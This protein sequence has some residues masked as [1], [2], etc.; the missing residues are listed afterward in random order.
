MKFSHVLVVVCTL[1]AACGYTA[2]AQSPV[3]VDAEMLQM[4]FPSQHDKVVSLSGPWS[5]V[6]DGEESTVSL[7]AIEFAPEATFTKKIQLD[8]SSVDNYAWSIDF[9]GAGH[10]VDVFVNDQFVGTHIGGDVRF[11]QAI[12]QSFLVAGENIVTVA[13]NGE[14]SPSGTVPV[15]GGSLTPSILA[16]VHRDVFLVGRPIVRVGDANLKTTNISSDQATLSVNT[17]IVTDNLARFVL[18]TDSVEIVRSEVNVDVAVVL[19]SPSG[20]IVDSVYRTVVMSSNRSEVV[21]EE[22]SVVGPSLWALGAPS[23]YSLE[24]VASVSGET[25]DAWK[26]DVSLFTVGVD[27]RANAMLVNGTPQRLQAIDYFESGSQDANH[28]VTMQRMRQDIEKILTLGANCVRFPYGMPH[29]VLL[30][31]C[32]KNGLAVMIDMPVVNVPSEL[33]GTDNF[34]STA[35]N[36]AGEYTNTAG[37]VGCILGFGLSTGLHEGKA[38]TYRYLDALSSRFAQ[39]GY[40]T[41]KTWSGDQLMFEKRGID[42]VLLDEHSETY[43]EQYARARELLSGT[44]WLAHFG[45]IVEPN[46]HQGYSNP[47]S[48]EAQAKHIR[49]RVRFLQEQNLSAGVVLWSYN[50]YTTARPL[51]LVRAD[52]PNL[53]SSGLVAQNREERFSYALTKALFNDEKEPVIAAGTWE[54][55]KP[56]MYTFLSIALLVLTLILIN[57]SRRFRENVARALVRPYNFYADIRDQ[58]IL[59]SVRTIILALVVALASG[60]YFSAITYTL[61]DTLL[62]DKWM[63]LLLPWNSL[64]EVADTLVWM[65]LGSTLALAGL[66]MLLLLC[67]AATIRIGSMFVRSRIFFSD[68]MI[69]ATWGALPAVFLLFGT[70]ALYKLLEIPEALGPILI[71]LVV[72][73]LW[74]LYRVLRGTAVIF[75]IRSLYAYTGGIALL[76]FVASLFTWYYNANWSTLA[77]VEYLLQ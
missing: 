34:I 58:R 10:R 77:Y 41:Y 5:R 47:Y 62:L 18:A 48:I 45:R 14:L 67:V 42:F 61:R 70:A 72:F 75:D 1:L 68:A 55:D 31:L 56:V 9:L 6:V 63:S 73:A 4:L 7:P 59:S 2:V 76:L 30:E 53:S 44:T 64:K 12:Q 20:A 21:A 38:G 49:D 57:S 40:Q 69:I 17:T 51:L 19:R 13:V 25:I 52:K 29:P 22:M 71:V 27:A 66:T 46:N 36:L 74:F 35:E 60:M 15:R 43:Q 24:V 33:V 16:G 8:K 32:R 11:S 3:G 26:R 65:P 50:D 28:G 37:N 54:E 39:A 23:S